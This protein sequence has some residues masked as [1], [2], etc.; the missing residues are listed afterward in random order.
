MIKEK[1]ANI[2]HT[3]LHSNINIK[4]WSISSNKP[5]LT[6]SK[7][8][9]TTKGGTRKLQLAHYVGSACKGFSNSA[10]IR[11]FESQVHGVDLGKAYWR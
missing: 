9:S 4:Q 11:N 2:K 8:Y 1:G 6:Y 3:R 10:S 5:A 7:V